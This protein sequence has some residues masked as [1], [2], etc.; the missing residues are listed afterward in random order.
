MGLNKAV[1]LLANF[2]VKV[3]SY[4]HQKGNIHSVAMLQESRPP[5][6]LSVLPSRAKPMK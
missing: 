1:L 3:R 5:F 4:V 6:P 2:I